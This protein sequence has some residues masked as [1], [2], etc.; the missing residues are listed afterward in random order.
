MSR[1]EYP[2]ELYP[3]YCSGAGY[4]ITKDLVPVL[5]DAALH[6]RTFWVDD[7]FI[8][9]MLPQ[10]VGDV[11]IIQIPKQTLLTIQVLWKNSDNGQQMLV[12]V[13][14]DLELFHLYW[15]KFH[16]SRE[17]KKSAPQ[18]P[19]SSPVEWCDKGSHLFSA[20]HF[21]ISQRICNDFHVTMVAHM[22]VGYVSE[23]IELLSDNC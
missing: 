20:L 3:A 8:S 12:H 11:T 17:N 6:V 2:K 1:E 13:A 15:N 21:W 18:L 9:G 16:Q 19:S 7:T 23:W 5:Y 22:Y 4:L 14:Q 10:A